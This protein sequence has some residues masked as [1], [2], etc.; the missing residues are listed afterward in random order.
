VDLRVSEGE[1][2]ALLGPN[3]SGKST[4]LRV[5]AGLRVPQRGQALWA[6]VELSR[7]ERLARARAIAFLPQTVT[8]LYNYRVLDVVFL[9]RHPHASGP[10]SGPSA[11]DRE[12]VGRAL[13]DCDVV[14]LQTRPFQELSGGERQRVLLAAALAQGAAL[15]LLDEPTAALDVHHQIGLLRILRELAGRGRTILWATHDLNLAAVFADRLLL[16]DHGRIVAEGPPDAVLRQELLQRVYGSGIWVGPHPARREAIC[17]LPEPGS[18]R[19][20]ALR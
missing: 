9:G 16:L 10:F 1:V 2:V 8:A 11:Q 7:W 20:Q 6:G 3:G 5:A 18:P 12:A 14:E 4:L 15:L 17:V 19:G 13:R